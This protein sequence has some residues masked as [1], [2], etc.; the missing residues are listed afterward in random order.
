[1]V[2]T[3]TSSQKTGEGPG[4][5]AARAGGPSYLLRGAH[6]LVLWTF[7]FAQPTFA[8]LDSPV[9]TVMANAGGIDL[10]LFAIGLTFVPPAILLLVEFAVARLAP[11]A[12]EV[13]HLLFV[14]GL[15][16]LIASPIVLRLLPS[17]S[18]SVQTVLALGAGVAFAL[19]YAKLPPLRSL[20]TALVPAPVVFVLIFLFTPAVWHFVKG[21]DNAAPT[22]R[23][24]ARAPVV[25]VIFDEFNSDALMDGS[26]KLDAARYPNFARL[27][28]QSTWFRNA[29]ADH[30]FTELAV[31]TMLSG[32]RV[33]EGSTPHLWDHPRNLFTMLGGYRIHAVEQVTDLCPERTCPERGS[34]P[35]RLPGLYHDLVLL[36]AKAVLPD[37]VSLRLPAIKEFKLTPQDEFSHLMSGIQPTQGRT[38]NFGHVGMPHMIHN[39]LPSGKGYPL[40]GESAGR[41][42]LTGGVLHWENEPW[43]ATTGWQRYLLQV[44]YTDRELGKILDRL[45]RDGVYDRAAIVV[46]ADH[47]VANNPND[48]RRAGTRTNL[49][50]I[51]PVPLFVKA[52]HQRRERIVDRHVQTVDF[53]PSLAHVLGVHVPFKTDGRSGFDPKLDRQR[54]TLTNLSGP[55]LTISAGA[56]DRR[57]AAVLKHQARLFGDGSNPDRIYEVGLD[58]R[59]WGRRVDTLSVSRSAGTSARILDPTSFTYDPRSAIAPARLFG[60]LSG[61]GA[62]PGKKLVIALNGRIRT[63]TQSYPNRGLVQFAS[64]L[65]P[66]HLHT[67][68]NTVEVF[69]LSGSGGSPRLELLG[70][71]S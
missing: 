24:A 66:S 23:T 13:V 33:P 5:E 32:Q 12:L 15:A 3:A 68:R 53:L 19:G 2:T 63:A 17:P 31:P 35:G 47:G 50:Q 45:K 48:E 1:L 4:D 41:T 27:A 62:R 25:F 36:G 55:A 22:Y 51:M 60:Q 21:D 20:A 8:K 39:R 67:G 61:A 58:R 38:L 71:T 16:A 7:A 10:V 14:A 44:G 54:L 69:G 28:Q 26:G 46:S 59:L 49:E 43:L 18:S 65:P 9:P 64:M 57:R 56:M 52:P 29:M 34:F 37:A 70:K 11:R 42:G 6:L 40:L 30:S